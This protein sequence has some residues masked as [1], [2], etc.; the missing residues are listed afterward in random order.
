M[1]RKILVAV[2]V[3]DVVIT[4]LVFALWQ[5]R[6]TSSE[7]NS[8]PLQMVSA[9]ESLEL[10]FATAHRQNDLQALCGLICWDGVDEFTKQSVQ[11]SI[12]DDLERVIARVD[13]VPGPVENLPTY[14]I[15]NT[16]YV[17]NLNVDG[18]LVVE[19]QADNSGRG[20]TTYLV[21]SHNGTRMIATAAP[22]RSL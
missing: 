15:N 8:R 12:Q 17:P 14:E 21:G 22:K 18:R 19:F 2:I 9:S 1:L 7:P 16:Q 20:S 6:S 10:A 3:G 5:P 4:A 13:Y 11:Q